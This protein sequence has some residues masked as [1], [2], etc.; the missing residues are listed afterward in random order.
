M[1]R[2]L[3]ISASNNEV[4]K[5]KNWTKILCWA[6]EEDRDYKHHPGP[7]QDEE[8]IFRSAY[9]PRG[10]MTLYSIQC[11]CWCSGLQNPW[12]GFPKSAPFDR[13]FFLILNV[14]VGR[15]LHSNHSA[16][17]TRFF[18]V[19]MVV[20]VCGPLKGQCHEIFC[21]MFFHESS[22]LKPLKGVQTK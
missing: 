6:Q 2:I 19:F 4:L 11:L 5:E 15:R 8:F 18:A 7:H 22:F 3:N 1:Q 16:N 9:K 12:E 10:F 20:V 21:F 13:E 14:A 17:L